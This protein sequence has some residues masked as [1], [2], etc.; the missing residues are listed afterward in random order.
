MGEGAGVAVELKPLAERTA[1]L[2]WAFRGVPASTVRGYCPDAYGTVRYF[3]SMPRCQADLL[4]T[5]VFPVL[6]LD[7]CAAISALGSKLATWQQ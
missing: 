5:W 4:V 2:R 6:W 1:M 7:G 3:I